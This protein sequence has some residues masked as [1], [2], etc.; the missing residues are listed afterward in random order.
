MIL[1]IQPWF[2]MD[3]SVTP[4]ITF[5]LPTSTLSTGSSEVTSATPMP[6]STSLTTSFTDNHT[7]TSH[8]IVKS[9]S[10]NAST[11]TVLVYMRPQSHASKSVGLS[12]ILIL[13][14]LLAAII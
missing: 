3:S 1:T 13:G 7:A 8:S 10:S 11:N 14:L 12:G 9:T 2:S 6:T 5:T 4:T